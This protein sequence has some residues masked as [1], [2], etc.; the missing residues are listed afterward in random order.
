MQ[1]LNLTESL[2][3]NNMNDAGLM[4]FISF[5][6]HINLR[7]HQL[8]LLF[9]AKIAE[10][11]E[12]VFE[13][14]AIPISKAS[15]FI[16]REW[17][18]DRR[19]LMNFSLT[20]V[21]E[22]GIRCFT[23]DLSFTS[24]KSS[25]GGADGD[26][27]KPI[28]S[29]ITARFSNKLV[30]ATTHPSVRMWL[31][32]FQNFRELHSECPLG[33]I[34]MNGNSDINNPEALS[35]HITIKST[36]IP[37]NIAEWRQSVDKLLE[38]VR[39]VMSFASAVVLHAP[40]CEYFDGCENEIVAWSQVSQSRASMRVIH[41]LNQE[42]IFQAAVTCYFSPP[43]EVSNLFHAIEWFSM[44]AT[45][46]EVRL[47]NAMTVL[48]NLVASNLEDDAALIL[49]K[50]NF[51]KVRKVLRGVIRSCIEKWPDN[52]ATPTEIIAELD[53]RLADLNRRSIINKLMI[54]INR[55]SV[56][57]EGITE[58]QIKAAKKA[59]DHIVHT[60]HYQSDKDDE[61]W[62]HV[63]VIRE[64]VVRFIFTAIG[65]KGQYISFVGGM[66]HTSF[67]PPLAISIDLTKSE[68][69]M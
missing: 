20:G 22:T 42:A 34:V 29:C 32:G 3:R 13:F 57:I 23:D 61:L 55:W 58:S 66:N 54:L 65:Y 68:S 6:G 25:I 62:D 15:S 31:K 52:E 28:G 56:P 46:N 60:G 27:L 26:T 49:E 43:V 50:K 10:N 24:M 39:R 8:P 19:S 41:Y 44:D 59:R 18:S 67:P 7:D 11:G 63:M 38:H 40:I 36:I 47:V 35:G 33:T 17:D 30:E 48:E 53:E 12:V 37:S 21:S 9:Q 5:T 64:L 2:G 45:Y 4:N 51:T 14:P 16:F 69:P 1:K